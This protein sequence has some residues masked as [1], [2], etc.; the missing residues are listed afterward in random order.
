MDV[1]RDLSYPPEA[2]ASNGVLWWELATYPGM[3]RDYGAERKLAAWLAF[4]RTVGDVF[5]TKE[6]RLALG[7]PDVPNA[8]EHLQ[9]RLRQLRKDD[10]VIPSTKYDRNLPP[11]HYRIDAVG[12]HPGLLVPRPVRPRISDRVRRSV[13]ERDGWRCSVC[14]VGSKEPYPDQPSAKAVLAI[15]HILSDE[16]GGSSSADNLRAE[17][18]RCNEPVRSDTPKP[19]T[20]EEVLTAVRALRNADLKRLSEWTDAGRR[21]REPVDEV[22]DRIRRL[23]TDERAEVEATI[24]KMTR[25]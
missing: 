15:G 13:L 12:W 25:R 4:N 5:T 23:P 3:K 16:F 18:S 21:K 20:S 14:G 6:V 7:D 9:R 2:F 10:W 24:S 17:C 22:Y 19:E 8:D 11:E 1:S